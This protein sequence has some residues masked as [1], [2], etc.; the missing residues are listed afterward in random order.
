MK[1]K[2]A[3]AYMDFFEKRMHMKI[4]KATDEIDAL[5][6]GYFF[7]VGDHVRPGIKTIEEFQEEMYDEDTMMGVIRI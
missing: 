1:R 3:V 2:Y 5:Y 6:K 7:F 4:I